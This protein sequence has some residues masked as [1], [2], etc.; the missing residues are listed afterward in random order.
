RK[1][2]FV[3]IRI[4]TNNG[5][6]IPYKNENITNVRP[7]GLLPI[8]DREILADSNVATPPP[9]KA[10]GE[11]FKKLTKS[12]FSRTYSQLAASIAIGILT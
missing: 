1:N 10:D 2:K 4:L 5:T 12:G 7:I 6:K 3:G 11:I 9:A 8:S